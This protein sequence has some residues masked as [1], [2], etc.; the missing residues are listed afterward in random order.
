MKLPPSLA[1]AIAAALLCLAGA[2]ACAQDDPV[3][4]E[5]EVELDTISTES[6]DQLAYATLLPNPDV[7]DP[8]LMKSAITAVLHAPPAKPKTIVPTGAPTKPAIKAVVIDPNAVA[9]PPTRLVFDQ[10]QSVQIH[11]DGAPPPNAP[12]PSPFV[13]VMPRQAD[14]AAVTLGA[15]WSAQDRIQAPLLS[16]LAWE[17]H[18][19][20]VSGAPAARAGNVRRSLRIT[21]MWD[22]PEDLSIGFTPGFTRGGGREFEHY[23][24][25]LAVTTVDKTR[26]ARW[27]SFV[28]VSGEKLA[29]N[30]VIDNSTAHVAAG[31]SYSASANTQ[32][33]IGV[34]RG[35]TWY[36][37]DLTSNVGFSVKF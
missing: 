22:T 27:R 24:T 19:D 31:A 8:T 11:A 14:P 5:V 25:G 9:I 16:A 35:T 29:F 20:V 32:L 34:S 36:S 21:A 4:P 1:P 6:L 3:A 12:D 18:A 7:A 28:E 37:N 23:E 13:R 10:N 17:A 26:C 30:N 2:S 15:R 33:D